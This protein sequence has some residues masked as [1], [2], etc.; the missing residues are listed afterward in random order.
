MSTC[1]GL[2]KARNSGGQELPLLAHP[3]ADDRHLQIEASMSPEHAPPPECLGGSTGD[4]LHDPA[5][6]VDLDAR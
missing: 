3:D 6:D 5:A 1:N 4:V 2:W